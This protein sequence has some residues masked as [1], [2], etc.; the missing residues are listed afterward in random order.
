MFSMEAAPVHLPP[1]EHEG[2]NFPTRWPALPPGLLTMAILTAGRW[3][4]T[5]F[6]LHFRGGK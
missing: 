2:S 1:T 5:G 3:Y 4:F 6:D